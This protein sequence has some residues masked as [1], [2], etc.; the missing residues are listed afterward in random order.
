MSI[1]ISRALEELAAVIAKLRWIEAE[2]RRAQ[3]HELKRQREQQPL[4]DA[5]ED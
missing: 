3:R 5:K 2:L 1:E 4:D